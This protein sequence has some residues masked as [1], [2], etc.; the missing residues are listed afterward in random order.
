MVKKPKDASPAAAAKPAASRGV[1]RGARRQIAVTFPPATVDQIDATA[2]RF[3]MS[4]A[5]YI[6][7]AVVKALE[8]DN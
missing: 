1:I 7:R 6:N 3:G 2:A 5:G 4:R 8:A